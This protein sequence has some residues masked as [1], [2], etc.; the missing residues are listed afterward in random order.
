MGYGDELIASGQAKAMRLADPQRRRV[1]ILDAYK[2]GRWHELWT[3]NPDIVRLGEAGDFLKIM[4]GPGARPYIAEKRADRWVWK[5]FR[6]TPADLYFTRFE[7]DF[8][9]R[10]DPGVVIEPNI[11]G[12]AS[13]NKD[14]GWERWVRFARM[15]AREGIKLA[16]LGPGVGGVKRIPGV[17][18]IQTASFREACAVLARAKAYVGHE[19]GLH[20]AAAA[21]GIPAVVIF[22]GFIS[23]R[24][25][26]YD[27]HVN[28]FTGIEPCGR[29]TPCSHCA[30][31]MAKIEPDQVL[32]AL[33]GILDVPAPERVVS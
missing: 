2:N 6:C 11:K 18:W 5:D 16:Q 13:P 30:I 8:A 10:F 4:N 15:A 28:L 22:G 21:V 32:E 17:Q 14:W 24:Q 31:A 26:G 1:R 29:R 3:G 33:K 19:G 7:R 23:P 9:A 27:G 12:K 20:H 25:T